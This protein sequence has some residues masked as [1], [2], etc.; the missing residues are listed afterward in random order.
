MSIGGIAN[1]QTATSDKLFFE[2]GFCRAS[3]DPPV[4]TSQI[5]SLDRHGNH[6]ALGCMAPM[7]GN[8]TM[9]V[10]TLGKLKIGET[11]QF[12]TTEPV[13]V[14]DVIGIR[15]QLP[16]FSEPYGLAG[17]TKDLGNGFYEAKR[18]N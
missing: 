15:T 12:G 10:S 14:G 13:K 2:C 8:E 9:N 16:H 6:G 18:I 17:I 4:W 11:F 1:E 3:C 5:P 7:A